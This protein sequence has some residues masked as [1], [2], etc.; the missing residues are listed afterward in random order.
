MTKN[1]HVSGVAKSSGQISTAS[2]DSVAT[3][4]RSNG[5]AKIV[6]IKKVGL[7]DVYNLEVDCYHNFAIN[8]GLIVH[9]CMDAFRYGAEPLLT[10]KAQSVWS[11]KMF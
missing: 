3:N 8:G 6:S 2:Q 11:R 9:N 10:G 1:L 7:E 5:L 4:A